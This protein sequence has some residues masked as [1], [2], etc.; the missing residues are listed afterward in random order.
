MVFIIIKSMGRSKLTLCRYSGPTYSSMDNMGS[1]Y[2]SSSLRLYP[3][4]GNRFSIFIDYFC[5]YLLALFTCAVSKQYNFV[6]KCEGEDWR[7]ELLPVKKISC[8]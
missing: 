2:F 1:L 3:T 6:F 5:L 7:E 8:L 4:T